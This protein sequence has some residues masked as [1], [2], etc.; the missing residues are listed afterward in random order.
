MVLSTSKWILAFVVGR[1]NTQKEQVG[2]MSDC[3]CRY[4][5]ESRLGDLAKNFKQYSLLRL[6]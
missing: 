6:L 3:I 2:R 1:Y 5:R 4:S